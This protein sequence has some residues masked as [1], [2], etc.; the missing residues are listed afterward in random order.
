MAR[1]TEGP[2]SDI[3][4]LPTSEDWLYLAAVLDLVT[5]KIVD[6]SMRA[7][8]RAELSG[9]A[10][11][12]AAQRPRPAAG[13]ICP[14]DRACP[15]AAEAYRRQ[16]AS[17]RAKPSMSRTACGYD[18][19]WRAPSTPS[20]SRSSITGVGPPGLRRCAICSLTLRAT[21]SGSVSTR[22]RPISRPV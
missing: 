22:P 7:H 2:R 19:A 15:Y 10:P 8:M 21:T 9:A 14:S 1:R 11:M 4:C 3:T 12:R 5:R 16:L 17:M 13:L 6:W 18:K 20:R